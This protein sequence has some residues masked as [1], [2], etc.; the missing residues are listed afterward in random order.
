MATDPNDPQQNDGT[1]AQRLWEAV[2]CWPR[3]G[4]EEGGGGF[5][6][7]CLQPGLMDG[8][9][10]DGGGRDGGAGAGAGAG[11]AA[12]PRLAVGWGTPDPNPSSASS[13]PEPPALTRHCAAPSELCRTSCPELPALCSPLGSPTAKNS[14]CPIPLPGSVLASR[15][16]FRTWST[17]LFHR[18][19]LRW[20]T[21]RS[22]AECDG[23]AEPC[24]HPSPSLQQLPV[25]ASSREQLRAQQR[26]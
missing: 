12:V 15:R 23:E 16:P 7:S 9:G 20:R 22:D 14:M 17:R 26:L 1:A 2:G 19:S 25:P 8:R 3:S 11:R 18:S 24:T 21:N 5:A 10:R 6:P 4:R 13:S